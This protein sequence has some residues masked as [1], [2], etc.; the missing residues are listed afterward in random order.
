MLVSEIM[1]KSIA[2]QFDF[3][4]GSGAQN[5]LNFSRGSVPKIGNYLPIVI[6][7]FFVDFERINVPKIF[8]KQ[9][10]HT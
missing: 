2:S 9:R 4:R 5:F 3:S 10:N 6:N 1:T 8:F 7:S